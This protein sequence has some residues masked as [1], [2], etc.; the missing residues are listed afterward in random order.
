[1]VVRGYRL[2]LRGGFNNITGHSNPNVVDNVVGGPTYLNEYGGPE[3]RAEFSTAFPRPRVKNNSPHVETRGCA[4]D[5]RHRPQVI[6][7]QEIVIV[8]HQP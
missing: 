6:W 7:I 3:P 4:A 8:G 1:M 2:A 5:V